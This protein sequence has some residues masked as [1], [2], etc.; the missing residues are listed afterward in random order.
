MEQLG[1]QLVPI[2]DTCITGWRIAYCATVPIPRTAL[3]LKS[4]HFRN[5]S[6]AVKMLKK[7]YDPGKTKGMARLL[8][9][10][11]LCLLCLQFAL[12]CISICVLISKGQVS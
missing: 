10:F 5:N 9:T 6:Q 12:H 8:T 3:M 11:A 4:T 7:Q 2:W 1:H